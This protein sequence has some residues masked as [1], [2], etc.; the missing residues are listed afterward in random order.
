MIA[1]TKK[2]SYRCRLWIG[3]CV[4][5]LLLAVGMTE[6]RVTA[7]GATITIETDRS[8]ITKGERFY[9]LI[10]V[11]SSEA[12]NGFEGYFSYDSR[13]M[14]YI[15]GGSVASG[16]DDTFHISDVQREE[17]STELKY[18]ICF[19]ARK[20]GD[21]SIRL[22]TPYAVYRAED[23]SQMSVASNG[24]NLVIHGKSKQ[25][26]SSRLK[27]LEVEGIELSPAFR[28]DILTYHGTLEGEAASL[29]VNA[30]PE[31]AQ[32]EVKIEG[33]DNLAE[34][35]NEIQ[36]HVQSETGSETV[37]RL[38]LEKRTS[39]ANPAESTTFSAAEAEDGNNR[40]QNDPAVSE[41]NDTGFSTAV[42]EQ[43]VTYGDIQRQQNRLTIQ[44]QRCLLVLLGAVCGLLFIALLSLYGKYRRSGKRQ[45]REYGETN[46]PEEDIP[47]TAD[48]P[49]E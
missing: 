30:T 47:D 48:E 5:L 21:C 10:T 37:Y 14:K 2:S 3:G 4:L 46:I 12:M 34:G 7:A 16:N 29:D 49:Q 1:K 6:K 24:M 40:S 31:N 23:S 41:Q 33:N 13:L 27:E 26:G 42:S 15:T 19:Q 39:S 45:Q 44:K 20:R 38:T 22:Q 32:A 9:L 28:P 35:E 25:Y 43:A 8:T 11:T 18:S 36:I 17:G